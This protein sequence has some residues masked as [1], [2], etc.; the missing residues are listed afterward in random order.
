MCQYSDYYELIQTLAV[1][2]L[3]LSL[4]GGVAGMCI[5]TFIL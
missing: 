5:N 1:S 3:F 2:E 4:G